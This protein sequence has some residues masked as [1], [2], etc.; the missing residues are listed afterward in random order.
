MSKHLTQP[1]Q[2]GHLC[3]SRL[4]SH[5]L[6]VSELPLLTFILESPQQY[7]VIE[8]NVALNVHVMNSDFR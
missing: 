3:H 8:N 2:V 6:H 4:A 1:R 7:E 5:S